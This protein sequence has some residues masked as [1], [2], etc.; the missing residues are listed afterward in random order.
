[1]ACFPRPNPSYEAASFTLGKSQFFLS[2]TDLLT[3]LASGSVGLV[4]ATIFIYWE[5]GGWWM[6]WSAVYPTAECILSCQVFRTL[7]LSD[8]TPGESIAM[9]RTED[10]EQMVMAAMDRV[11]E[12]SDPNSWS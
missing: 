2:P 11:N 9:I 3:A 12:V 10:V 4:F 1:M 6:L 5:G 7:L 8:C